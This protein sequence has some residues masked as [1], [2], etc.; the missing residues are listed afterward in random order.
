M[1]CHGYMPIEWMSRRKV[2][3]KRGANKAMVDIVD[4]RQELPRLSRRLDG[5]P[6][7]RSSSVLGVPDWADPY[8]RWFS[9]PARD[10]GE[11][12]PTFLMTRATLYTGGSRNSR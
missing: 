7:P 3:E 8:L 4:F 5:H 6:A 2:T 1:G 12:I 11:G 9:T 10:R